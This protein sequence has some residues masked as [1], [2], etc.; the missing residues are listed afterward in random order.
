M[1]LVK[2]CHLLLLESLDGR[3]SCR[4]LLIVRLL[5]IN[6]VLS[7]GL[8]VLMAVLARLPILLLPVGIHV[9]RIL[10]LLK[11]V[12]FLLGLEHVVIVAQEVVQVV[13]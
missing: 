12:A 2:H 9:R 8:V 5:L 10:Q 1:H 4:L 3:L 6:V 11:V 7:C 13:A